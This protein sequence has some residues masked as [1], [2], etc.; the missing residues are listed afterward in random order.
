V[1]ATRAAIFSLSHSV[2]GLAV[3]LLSIAFVVG[4]A[5]TTIG[6]RDTYQGGPLPRPGRIIVHDYAA[7]AADLPP[8]SEAAKTMT[9]AAPS[10]T[11]EDLEAGRELGSEVAER[12]VER[13]NDMGMTAVR[14]ADSPEPEVN[15]FVLIGYFTS[16]EEG[17]AAARTLVGFG[18]GAA[19]VGVH[20]EGYRKTE[21][22]LVLLGGGDVDSE[23]GKSPGLV[24]PAVVTIAT[25]NPLGLVVSGAVKV[26]GEATGNSGA[27]GSAKRI[28][29]QIG[30]VLEARFREQGWI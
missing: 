7:T 9:G 30:E 2:S 5:S 10:Q 1:T 4:C 27:E 22:G 20:A 19:S 26:A 17:S 3:G 14:A 29:D 18:K 12:L 21:Q 15:D 24:V 16:V 8:W 23:G 11:A 28:A 6:D 25:S 13:I